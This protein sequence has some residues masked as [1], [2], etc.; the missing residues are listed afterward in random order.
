MAGGVQPQVCLH[1]FL[2][3]AGVD[4]ERREEWC[5]GVSKR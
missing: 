4:R 2:H 3:A 1:L 5:S